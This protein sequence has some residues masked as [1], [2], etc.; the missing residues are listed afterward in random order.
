MGKYKRLVMQMADIIP[1]RGEM[2]RE[3]PENEE[4][5]ERLQMRLS[6]LEGER[7]TLQMKVAEYHSHLEDVREDVQED[8]AIARR[9]RQE[10]K[11][12]TKELQAK[13]AEI[14]NLRNM[15]TKQQLELEHLESSYKSV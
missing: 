3:A 2:Q 15:I 5:N 14:H 10:S 11:F 13:E 9:D 7:N 8:R 1:E 12:L 6:I 4:S